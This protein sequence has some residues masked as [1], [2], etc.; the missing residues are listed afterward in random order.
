MGSSITITIKYRPGKNN[1]SVDAL[2]RWPYGADD[3][4]MN[5]YEGIKAVN[6]IT[7][8]ISQRRLNCTSSGTYSPDARHGQY[9][10]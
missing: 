1:A 6:T 5:E 7:T 2:S 3:Q 10:A 8:K 4:Y 9:T